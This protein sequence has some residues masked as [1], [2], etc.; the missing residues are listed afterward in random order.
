MISNAQMVTVILEISQK[1]STLEKC[2]DPRDFG[3]TSTA[4]SAKLVLNDQNAGF[5]VLTLPL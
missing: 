3:A 1:R 5:N 2:I 4:A